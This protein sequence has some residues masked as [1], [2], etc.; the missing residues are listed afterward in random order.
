MQKYVQKITQF[1][2]LASDE[3][4]RRSLFGQTE[5]DGIEVDG[6]DK[7]AESHIRNL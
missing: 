4:E 6:T 3:E 2:F 7:P 1:F 5:V